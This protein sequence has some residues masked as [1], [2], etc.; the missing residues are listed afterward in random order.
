MNTRTLTAASTTIES[1]RSITMLPDDHPCR[2]LHGHSFR[3]SVLTAL[4]SEWS[5]FPGSDVISLR[6]ALEESVAP[7]N[8]SY[9]NQALEHPTDENLARWIQEH[10]HLPHVNR[11][12]VRSM[13]H[14]GVDL[15]RH[16]VVHIW[17]RYR[18]QAAHQL[19]NVPR[20]HKCGRMHGHRFEVVIHATQRPNINQQSIDYDHIDRIW[21][22]IQSELD[23]QCLNNIEGLSNP[24]SELISS[25]LW[26]RLKPSL[27]ELSSVTV[28]ETDSCG[29]NFDGNIYRIWKDFT[30]DSAVQ[31]RDTR[32][33][34]RLSRLHGHTFLLR[35]QLLAPLDQIMGWT[36]DFGDVKAQFE[37]IFKQLDHNPLHELAGISNSDTTSLAHWIYQTAKPLLPQIVQVDL[38]EAQGCGA[39][40]AESLESPLLPI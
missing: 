3:I 10:L 11:L 6:K 8:Y 35:L 5:S 33:D 24:T 16:G 28:F 17:R 1:A 2:N 31:V 40:V 26:S 22:P 7:L 32:T 29:A 38:Y 21:A 25:W 13:Q 19:P 30:L 39:I 14:Q 12:S 9:L 37:P 20:G 34:H 27:P 4:P 15:D 36:I 23:Y 18:F